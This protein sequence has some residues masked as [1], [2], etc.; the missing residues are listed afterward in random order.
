MT[1]DAFH[2]A[3]LFLTQPLLLVAGSEAGTRWMSEVLYQRAASAH[4]G[5]FIVEEPPT[6]VCTTSPNG[7]TARS[8]ASSPSFVPTFDSL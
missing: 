7:S 3:E 5:L 1:F 8:P 2:Q 6:S 4:K